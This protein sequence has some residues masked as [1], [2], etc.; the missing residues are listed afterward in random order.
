[1]LSGISIPL[2]YIVLA[3]LQNP[4]PTQPC[5]SVRAGG[6]H[7]HAREISATP[8]EGSVEIDG[9]LTEPAWALAK[10]A[11]GFTQTDPMEGEPA[12][13]TPGVRVLIGT[14][15]LYI[16]ARL[17]DRGPGRVKAVLARRDDDVDSDE[18]DVYLDTFHD[19]LSGVRF[20]ITPG[21]AILDGIL[22]SSAQG[23]DEDDSWD[24]VWESAARVDSLGWTAELRIPLSQLRY[25]STANG[26]WG[27]QLYRKILRK[28]EEDW[29]SFVPKSEFGGVSR[30][31]HLVSLGKLRPQRRLE[32]APYLLARA[33]Y[34]PTIA[35]D[36][37]R[38]GHDYNGSAGLGPQERL[39]HRLNPHAPVN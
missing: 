4:M 28:G 14:D 15:A 13:E 10:P 35:G 24:P 3:T 12:T 33:A 19:H 30:Y 21:G 17:Y 39:P 7:A 6:A 5:D 16:G 18:L 25:N 8:L 9:Y 34:Q 1:M 20:R 2:A 37:F 27:I 32:L 22:G 11:S 23:S 29:F 31:A 38:T 36:P 26:V